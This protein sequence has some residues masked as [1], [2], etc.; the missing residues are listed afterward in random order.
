M[1]LVEKDAKSDEPSG[2]GSKILPVEFRSQ[3]R[4]GSIMSTLERVPQPIVETVKYLYGYRC[5]ACGRSKVL[6]V[7]HLKPRWKAGE[8]HSISNLAPLC[9]ECHAELQPTIETPK[10]K[11]RWTNL[12]WN[13]LWAH[14]S[15]YSKQKQSSNI[16]NAQNEGLSLNSR[17]T[18]D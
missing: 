1:D 8:N 18:I 6:T 2:A 9:Y 11:Y 5:A 10:S 12:L 13:G 14:G 4:G 17:P 7:H 16:A 3:P 15:P